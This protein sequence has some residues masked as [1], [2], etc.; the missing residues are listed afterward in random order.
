MTSPEPVPCPD[1]PVPFPEEP[2]PFPDDAV[3]D[4]VTTEGSTLL[5]TGETGQD[6]SDPV[7]VPAPEAD[8]AADDEPGAAIAAPISPPTT[9]TAANA[10][11]SIHRPVVARMSARGVSVI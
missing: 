11:A 9:P 2:V 7:A 4:M 10:P 8:D 1:E 6:V 5:A 3:A